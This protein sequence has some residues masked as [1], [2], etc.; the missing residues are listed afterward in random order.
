MSF[1]GGRMGK[2]GRDIWAEPGEPTSY[3]DYLKSQQYQDLQ[4]TMQQADELQSEIDNSPEGSKV[5]SSLIARLQR[6][7]SRVR[8]LLKRLGKPVLDVVYPNVKR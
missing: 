1:G 6:T 5:D 8:D 2:I 4:S 7:L 3:E